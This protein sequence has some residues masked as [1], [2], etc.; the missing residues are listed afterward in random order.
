MFDREHRGAVRLAVGIVRRRNNLSREQARA[1]REFV[2]NDEFM[3]DVISAAAASGDEFPQPDPSLP[4]RDG[5]RFRAWLEAIA[6][7]IER[8]L[9]LLVDLIP[10]LFPAAMAAEAEAEPGVIAGPPG[11]AGAACK[12]FRV[13]ID[14]FTG[15][16]ETSA[17]A[18]RVFKLAPGLTLLVDG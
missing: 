18:G 6:S 7:F 4:P 14:P 17:V 15:C 2:G 16:C 3:A 12:S 13:S 11:C 9:P 1:L 8:I 10:K 5:S